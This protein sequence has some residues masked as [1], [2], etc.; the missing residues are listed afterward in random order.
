[1]L[2]EDICVQRINITNSFLFELNFMGSEE[3]DYDLDK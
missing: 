2:C 1:M 3:F